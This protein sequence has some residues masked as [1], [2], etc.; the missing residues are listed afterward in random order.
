MSAVGPVGPVASTGFWLHR[1]ALTYLREL[2]ARL[3]P[4]GLTHTQFSLLAA[5]SWLGRRSDPPTQQQA[6]VFAGTDR[7]MTSKVLRT[8]EAGGLVQRVPDA[9]DARVR[10][11]LPTPAGRELLTEATR[12]A[13]AVDADLFGAGTELRDALAGFVMP[14]A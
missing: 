3:R 1:A 2:D 14:S 7:M 13:R 4:L 6:A 11:V 12:A 5:V 8:L 9:L 10:R